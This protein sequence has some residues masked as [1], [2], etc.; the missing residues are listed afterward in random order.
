MDIVLLGDFIHL[1]TLLHSLLEK[2][3]LISKLDFSKGIKFYMHTQ[4]AW[5]LSVLS[6]EMFGFSHCVYW[7]YPRV[8][9]KNC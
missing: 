5:Q 3:M 7:F 9:P 4:Y 8:W 1:V 6:K 2:W